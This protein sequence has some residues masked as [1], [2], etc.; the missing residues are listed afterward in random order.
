MTSTTTRNLSM[1]LFRVLSD[2]LLL[3][4]ILTLLR[5]SDLLSLSRTSRY[6][7]VFARNEALWRRLVFKDRGPKPGR[8]IYRGSWLLTYMFPGPEHDQ[9]CAAHPLVTHPVQIQ[10]VVSEHLHNQWIRSNMFFGHFYPPPPLPP[11]PALGEHR[12][13]NPIIPIED[14]HELNTETFYRRYAYPNRPVMIQNSGVETWPAWQ[15]WTPE[16]LASKYGDTLFRVSNTDSNTQP[17][18]ELYLKDFLHYLKYNKDQDPLYLFD[19]CFAETVP[20]MGNEYQIQDLPTAG[21][22]LDPREP[23][24]RGT[25]TLQG[26]L[27]ARTR[28]LLLTVFADVMRYAAWNTLLSGHKRWALQTIYVPSGWWHMVLNMDNTV[29]V[30]QNYVDETNLSR[31]KQSMLVDSSETTQVRRWG[32]LVQHIPKHRPDLASAIQDSPEDILIAKFQGQPMWLDPHDSSSVVQW[33]SRARTAL[34]QCTGALDVR[35]IS[36][37]STGHNLCFLSDQG[38]V[39]FFTPFHDGYNSFTSEVNANIVLKVARG[40][41]EQ[42]VGLS[43]PRM[44]GYG[45]LLDASQDTVADW[46]WPYIITE[47]TGRSGRTDPASSIMVSAREYMLEDKD[48][49]A[50]FLTPI[51]QALRHLHTMDKSLINQIPHVPETSRTPVAHA[52]N[53]FRTVNNHL[54]WRVFPRHLLELL[55]SYLPKDPK[56]LFNPVDGCPVATLVHGDV[57]PGNILGYLVAEGNYQTQ[58]S[59][60][61][62]QAYSDYYA[63]IF[64]PTSLI[65][66][67]DAMFFGDPLIDIVSIFVTILN[68]RQDLGLTSKLVDYW[69][70]L[71]NSSSRASAADQILAKRCMWHVLLWPSEGLSLHLTRCV[72]EIGE[73]L[74]WEEV[75]QSIFGWWSSA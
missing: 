66:F 37:V 40:Q 23:E 4:D 42:D 11:T 32:A 49:Y 2:R 59:F 6:F 21:Y 54:R 57:N 24:R 3:E 47:S 31:V 36:F 67:G 55:P 9:A 60:E 51:L 72:P 13:V 50:S 16:A 68:C 45:H 15:Q 10:G 62:P 29:A 18:I 48:E 41:G 7:H 38:F 44:L 1:G 30:T 65:D 69:K 46:R 61:Q 22:L 26:R 20:D 75:E 58:A 71:T 17:T 73:M 35:D 28:Q 12:P 52:E 43:T 8:L 64:R 25:P 70:T 39:K 34:Q 63:P 19:P 5:P 27:L 53:C 56:Q 14:Y 74:T 33:Q